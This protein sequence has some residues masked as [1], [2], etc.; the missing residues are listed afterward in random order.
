[1]SIPTEPNSADR[2]LAEKPIEPSQED[3]ARADRVIRTISDTPEAMRLSYA[4]NFCAH[5]SSAVAEAVA[6]LE[7]RIKSLEYDL[8][9]TK[10]ELRCVEQN[11]ERSCKELFAQRDTAE[12]ERDSLK[13]AVA[14]WRAVAEKHAHIAEGQTRRAAA[15]ELA[16]AGL[17]DS[18][19]KVRGSLED[20]RD[21]QTRL[22]NVALADLQD[23]QEENESL[24]LVAEYYAKGGNFDGGSYARLKLAAL[25]N[26][27][28]KGGA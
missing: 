24:L 3:F 26:P 20:E 13:Q 17:A 10:N 21:S 22:A 23:C 19:D 28:A 8:K 4:H 6:G 2:A 16:V 11:A 5:R 25:R 7:A 1:M 12:S 9:W 18:A 14:E 15:A 27:E